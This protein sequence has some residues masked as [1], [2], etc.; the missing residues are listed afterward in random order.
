MVLQLVIEGEP[1]RFATRASKRREA[2]YFIEQ[3]ELPSGNSLDIIGIDTGKLL[4][5][6]SFFILQN[7]KFGLLVD[8]TERKLFHHKQVLSS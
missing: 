4:V 3:I 2:G 1:C 7:F 6:A 5:G 8:I